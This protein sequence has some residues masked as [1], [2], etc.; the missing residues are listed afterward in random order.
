[1]DAT[2]HESDERLELY[3]LERLS[4]SDIMQIEEH[5]L[6]CDSCR[7]RLEETA[8]FALAMRDTLREG[9]KSGSAFDSPRPAWLG[10]LIKPQFVMAGTL[11][12]ALVAV[13]LVWDSHSGV[14]P[15]A[16]LQLN[17]MR[18]SEAQT[19]E[20]SRELDLTLTDAAGG[21]G[22]PV[23]EVVDNNGGQQLWTGTPQLIGGTARVKVMKVLPAGDYLVR[24]YYPPGHLV[25]EY[26][27]RVK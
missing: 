13:V 17:A 25:H 23:V 24:F 21:T 7:D 3:A 6:V 22:T 27:F 12:T 9:I 20:P 14:R 4:D 18:G 8:T 26:S 15:L 5:L 16:A 19:V 10:W 11:A 1:M 2:F